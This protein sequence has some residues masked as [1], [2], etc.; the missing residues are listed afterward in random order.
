MF[1]Y[2]YYKYGQSYFHQTI[3]PTL[4]TANFPRS[5]LLNQGISIDYSW[6]SR[7]SRFFRD[8]ICR[9]HFWFWDH[10]RSNLGIICGTGI[11]CGRG[12]GLFAGPYRSISVWVSFAV[13]DH[14]R[15]CTYL[16]FMAKSSHLAGLAIL[17]PVKKIPRST[18]PLF[19]D[20]VQKRLRLVHTSDG[21]GIGSARS[22]MIQCKSKRGIGSGVGSSTES[23]SEGSEEFLFLPIPLPLPSLPIQ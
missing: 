11:I 15:R 23:E 5:I 12:P 6:S 3:Y 9:N 2:F 19:L 17:D 8:V 20:D 7:H 13:G 10:L 22:V 16:L 21:I 14:L 4:M 18:P 1:P